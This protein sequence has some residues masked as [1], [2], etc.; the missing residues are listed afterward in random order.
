MSIINNFIEEYLKISRI[1]ENNKPDNI[2]KELSTFL[3]YTRIKDKKKML[4]FKANIKNSINEPLSICI[5]GN[6]GVGKTSFI[7]AILGGNI[8]SKKNKVNATI[9]YSNIPYIK[10]H[11]KDGV[12]TQSINMLDMISE[13]EF[14]EIFLDNDI[15]KNITIIENDSKYIDYDNY[16]ICIHINDKLDFLDCDFAILSKIDLLTQD[17]LNEIKITIKDKYS[18]IESSNIESLQKTPIMLT[19][20]ISQDNNIK[21]VLEN[22]IIKK[23]QAKK[24]K[25]IKRAMVKLIQ[26]SIKS[27]DELIDSYLELHN[28]INNQNFMQHIAELSDAI[29]SGLSN[30]NDDFI[31]NLKTISKLCYSN[32]ISKKIDFI[33]KNKLLKVKK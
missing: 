32:I 9:K 14:I 6:T 1:N 21:D 26:D 13:C 8:V 30:A 25:R 4:D 3:E 24:T 18:L 33:N 27:Y 17:E 7:N 15:L 28:I 23:A 29:E 19:S 16:D 10:I 11:T 5:K 31:I 22:I 2:L 12:L 20:I